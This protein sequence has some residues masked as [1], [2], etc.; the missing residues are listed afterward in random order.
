VCVCVL[1]VPGALII[2]HKKVMLTA[3]YTFSVLIIGLESF[4][5]AHQSKAKPKNLKHGSSSIKKEM[6]TPCCRRL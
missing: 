4:Q 1:F 3:S 5:G 6:P 2:T